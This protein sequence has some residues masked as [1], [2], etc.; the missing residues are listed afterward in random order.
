MSLTLLASWAADVPGKLWSNAAKTTPATDGGAVAAVEIDAGTTAVDMVQ[1]TGANQPIY[2]ANY[3]STGYPALQ[4]DGSNDVMSIAHNVAWNAAELLVLIVFDYVGTPAG[5]DNLIA[6]KFSNSSWFDG[7]NINRT[8]ATVRCGGG[9]YLT[10]SP[11][12]LLFAGGRHAFGLKLKTGTPACFLSER[13]FT[14]HSANVTLSTNTAAWQIGS[15]VAA[16]NFPTPIALRQFALHDAAGVTVTELKTLW[17]T[18]ASRW[19]T[20]APAWAETGS[21]TTRP[22]HPMYQQVIG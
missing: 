21:S 11:G 14:Q 20:Q 16:G 4:F 18:I 10:L 19:G 12:N 1:G 5:A 8:G 17:N 6:V 7:P 9:S 22:Q 2:R 3:N 15:G 13:D